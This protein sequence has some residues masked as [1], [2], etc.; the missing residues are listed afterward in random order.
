MEARLFGQARASTGASWSQEEPF[1]G[2]RSGSEICSLYGNKAVWMGKASHGASWSQ[3]EPLCDLWFCQKVP[4]MET[5]L[6]GG[7]KPRW[8]FVVPGGA[9]SGSAVGSLY[10]KGPVGW[11][12][13]SM[14]LLG[15]KKSPDVAK[16]VVLLR[17]TA[18]GWERPSGLVSPYGNKA[19]GMGQAF[20]G[21][22]CTMGEPLCDLWSC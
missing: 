18:F 13:E 9:F 19:F 7:K 14:G 21:S 4:D 22:S 17:S 2:S 3:G 16:E 5:R 8:R 10:G 11:A 15:P 1:C 12:R 20:H 6:W